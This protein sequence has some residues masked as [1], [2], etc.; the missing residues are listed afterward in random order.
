MKP[1]RTRFWS[2]VLFSILSPVMLMAQTNS[3]VVPPGLTNV[4]GSGASGILSGINREQ[5][6]YSAAYFPAQPII[7]TGVRYRPDVVDV[8]GQAFTNTISHIQFNLSATTN[9]PDHLNSTFAVN[10]GTNLTTVF[11][12]AL[13][14]SS[15]FSGPALGPKAFDIVVNFTTPFLYNPLAGNLM[16]DIKNFSGEPTSAID[17]DVSS[18]DFA[19]R[20]SNGDVN[21]AAGTS[22]TAADAL[23]IIYTLTDTNNSPPVITNQPQNQ[24]VFISSNVTF[25]VT[26]G[27][28]QPLS[29]QWFYNAT[30][31]I[32]GATNATLSLTNVQFTNSGNYNV[33]VT[34]AYGSILSS[35]A[36]L[37]VVTGSGLLVLPVQSQNI[38]GDAESGVLNEVVRYQNVYGAAQFSNN[39]IVINGLRFRPNTNVA[40]FSVT[41][42]K[43]Q[44]N[45]STTTAQPGSLSSTFANNVG[46]DDTIVF[47]GS[48]QISSASTGPPGGPRD[49]D[50]IIPLTN[51]FAYDPTKGNLLMEVRNFTGAP[52]GN[53]A[54]HTGNPVVQASRIYAYDAFATTA[55]NSGPGGVIIEL[56]YSSFNSPVI[57]VQPQSQAVGVGSNATFAVTAGGTPPLSYQWFLNGTNALTGATNFSFALNSAQLTNAGT[58]SVQ[59]TNSFGSVV[60]SNAVL[61]VYGV[62][63]SITTQ[64]QNQTVLVG[65]TATFSTVASG[66]LPLTYQWFFNGTTSLTSAT[67]SS[68]ALTNVQMT[69]AGNYSVQV[70]NAFGS[71]TSSNALL[72][73]NFPPAAIR[74]VGINVPAANSVS[75]PVQITA[76]GNEYAMA[77]SVNFTTTALNYAGATLGSGAPGASLVVNTNLIGSGKLGFQIIMPSFT[78][79]A[80]GTQEV[81]RVGFTIPVVTTAISTTVS[82]GDQPIGRSLADGQAN[83]L[84]ATYSSGNVVVAA[85]TAIEGD[86]TPRPNG[87]KTNALTDWILVG[88]YAARLDYPTNANE[89][90]RA[91]SAPRAT[92]GDGKIAV[93][94]WVQAG[95]YADGL[96]PVTPVGGPTNEISSPGAGP[97]ASRVVTITNLTIVQSQTG[98]ISV[99][100]AAQGNENALGFSLGF[101][102]ASL[103]FVSASLGGDA[104]G[105]TYLFN[106]NQTGAGQLGV[107]LALPTGSSFAAGTKEIFRVTMRASSTA[108]ASSS[109]TFTDQL[110]PRETSD[111]AANALPTSYANA[112]I[113]THPLSPTLQIAVSGTNILLAWPTWAADFTLQTPSNGVLPGLGWAAIITTPQTNGGNVQTTLPLQQT[114]QFFRLYHP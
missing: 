48:L 80:P 99:S 62:P 45:F 14:I 22:D 75:V 38:A 25:S 34:N 68:L 74:V 8:G 26:A 63:P 95:R 52:I 2:G 77:F 20:V 1:N 51:S 87:D 79:L 97:S 83:S 113:S 81:V 102:P 108:A 16:I 12:G 86:V 46:A 93:T 85:A 49:F 55:P 105:A 5:T 88:R 107:V 37:N 76:N 101:D 109:M 41:I 24:T 13:S 104:T 100:L 89:F 96:D 21:A 57:L 31:I 82:F 98:V 44:F 15:Q 91:D 32:A 35:N 40:P 78:T 56:V 17:A 92:Q 53:I 84:S 42:S 58:Y 60:S 50:I 72:T 47:G 103:S 64:P 106:T 69:N 65:S 3:L 59:V 67:N 73:V 110:V 61:T 70:T 112:T 39:A 29:Y 28:S 43:I 36:V 18:G 114:N 9:A 33:Q 94:D 66:S 6:V 10:N 30:N 19:S 7:I 23:Q 11:D 90:Q 111:A 54:D 27:G 71:I 4:E